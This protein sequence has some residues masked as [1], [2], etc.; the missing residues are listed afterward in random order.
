M[1]HAGSGAYSR[2]SGSWSFSTKNEWI[3][4]I[5]VTIRVVAV[6]LRARREGAFH[7]LLLLQRLKR[8]HRRIKRGLG[9]QIA[10]KQQRVIRPTR[11]GEVVEPRVTI[12]QPPQRHA[13]EVAGLD[14]LD[15][16][17][18]KRRVTVGLPLLNFGRQPLLVGACAAGLAGGDLGAAAPPRPDLDVHLGDHYLDSQGGVFGNRVINH[19]W[20][21]RA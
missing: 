14:V 18:E 12:V 6:T 9:L 15:E 3:P 4:M 5:V 1:P 2:W 13:R 16:D 20:V 10:V 8:P 11:H 7:R 17:V 19:L 21:R